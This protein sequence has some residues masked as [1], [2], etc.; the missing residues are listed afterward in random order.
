MADKY[1]TA[2][3]DMSRK[4]GATPNSQASN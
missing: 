3:V 2:N 4:L 1:L